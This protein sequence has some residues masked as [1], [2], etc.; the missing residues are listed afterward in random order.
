MMTAVRESTKT[1][2]G[3]DILGL[4]PFCFI[5]IFSPIADPVGQTVSLIQM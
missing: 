4:V 5:Y 3:V 1:N 2:T